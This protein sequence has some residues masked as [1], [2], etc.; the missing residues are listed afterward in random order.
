MAP[1]HQRFYRLF[2]RHISARPP[3]INDFTDC[4]PGEY[5]RLSR[6]SADG[7]VEAGSLPARASP[8]LRC[9]PAPSGPRRRES[10]TALRASARRGRMGTAPALEPH[11]HTSRSPRTHLREG[12][13]AQAL[14]LGARRHGARALLRRG[15]ARVGNALGPTRPT[16]PI[17]RTKAVT[18]IGKK[19]EDTLAADHKD[20]SARRG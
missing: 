16:P 1:R 13:G 2:F 18:I 15:A 4:A 3:E 17:D 9:A 11:K 8:P 5:S 7:G 10:V 14:G 6:P 20:Q 12:D 19:G